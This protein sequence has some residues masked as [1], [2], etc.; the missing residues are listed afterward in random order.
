MGSSVR[1]S[2]VKPLH[3]ASLFVFLVTCQ[4]LFCLCSGSATVSAGTRELLTSCLWVLS[5][6]WMPFAEPELPMACKSHGQMLSEVHQTTVPRSSTRWRC[7]LDR[8]LSG[9]KLIRALPNGAPRT[10]RPKLSGQGCISPLGLRPSWQS[11]VP[12]GWG[13]Q[14]TCLCLPLDQGS[15]DREG[16]LP[17]K[18]RCLRTG[19]PSPADRGSQDRGRLHEDTAHWRAWSAQPWPMAHRGLVGTAPHGLHELL[20]L[21][22]L[23]QC[24]PQGVLCAHQLVLQPQELR[25]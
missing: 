14:T 4:V 22:S 20:H 15:Q 16:C 8:I 24:I 21:L 18:T 19:L 10:R 12:L 6:W 1:D 9:S 11:H 5:C 17:L 25:C 3:D 7:L 13:S 23:V 2:I